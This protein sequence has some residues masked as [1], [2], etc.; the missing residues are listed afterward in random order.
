MITLN[1]R[2][3]I[4]M[5]A[6]NQLRVQWTLC[7]AL[8]RIFWEAMR[9]NAAVVFVVVEQLIGLPN[10]FQFTSDGGFRWFAIE[11]S[12]ESTLLWTAGRTFTHF[13]HQA[14]SITSSVTSLSRAP[15]IRRRVTSIP[16]GCWHQAWKDERVMRVA[17]RTATAFFFAIKSLYHFIYR[18]RT[19]L[20]SHLGLIVTDN[21]DYF[22]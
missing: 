22:D 14:D 20:L 12:M 11:E 8:H 13:Y 3:S 5:T 9:N 2:A 6:V 17:Y 10:T 19:I 16:N 1:W 21:R 4:T 7:T 18:Q 15:C